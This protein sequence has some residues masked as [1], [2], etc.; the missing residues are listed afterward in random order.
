MTTLSLPKHQDVI[1]DLID[2]IKMKPFGYSPT[3]GLGFYAVNK[4]GEFG[5]ATMTPSRYAAFDGDSA[6]LYDT[7]YLFEETE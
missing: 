1:Q 3:F 4:Q 6:S 7:A 2:T 5:A